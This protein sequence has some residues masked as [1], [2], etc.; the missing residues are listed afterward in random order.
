MAVGSA[1]GTT[2]APMFYRVSTDKNPAHKTIQIQSDTA[3]VYV[4]STL[5]DAPL[6]AAYTP[7][8]VFSPFIVTWD[9]PQ[10]PYPATIEVNVLDA[11]S[12]QSLGTTNLQLF[13]LD[14]FK[15]RVTY[16]SNNPASHGYIDAMINGNRQT[17]FGQDYI[18]QDFYNDDCW[19]RG[20]D[21]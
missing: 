15:M 20:S 2:E 9:F 5:E 10:L 8:N 16:S 11:A 18:Q 19:T 3:V 1:F 21:G 13:G 12:H 6:G 14:V 7:D 4:F 17:V